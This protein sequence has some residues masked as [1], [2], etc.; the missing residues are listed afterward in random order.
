MTVR[1][2]R[3]SLQHNARKYMYQLFAINIIII[4]M[5]VA[6]LGVEFAN[7]Y[8]IE[9]IL[10]GVIY[11]IKL[12]LE[13][14]VLSKL[15]QFA[16][17]SPSSIDGGGKPRHPI[18][19]ANANANAGASGNNHHRKYS[20]DEETPDFVDT[21]KVDGDFTHATLPTSA[22]KSCRPFFGSNDDLTLAM[23]KNVESGSDSDYSGSSSRLHSA[24]M[25][26][27]PTNSL[28]PT[29]PDTDTSTFQKFYLASP[30]RR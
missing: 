26:R 14:V 18:A 6:L 4:A 8:I 3:T 5:D 12:K 1:L 10:K 20:K 2:L 28:D 29:V 27:T 13:F 30:P 7:L 16:K 25:P 23:F 22:R 19:N 11:S 15:V 9:T 21:S 17:G 24:S